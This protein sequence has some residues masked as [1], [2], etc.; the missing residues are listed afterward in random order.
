VL[1]MDNWAMRMITEH[2]QNLSENVEIA[3]DKAEVLEEAWNYEI[4][5]EDAFTKLY[6][7]MQDIECKETNKKQLDTILDQVIK[8]INDLKRILNLIENDIKV[9]I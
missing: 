9:N 1:K 6:K 3:R 2:I 8:D 7:D 5:I 4:D